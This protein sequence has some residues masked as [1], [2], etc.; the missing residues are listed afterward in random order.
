MDS[1][2][3][4]NALLIVIAVALVALVFRVEPALVPSAHAQSQSPIDRG[5]PYQ[6]VMGCY[7]S[8]EKPCIPTALRVD[9]NGVVYVRQ[10]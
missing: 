9:P 8:P 2:R 4:T 5:F 1:R 3:L 7:A 10:P 6:L